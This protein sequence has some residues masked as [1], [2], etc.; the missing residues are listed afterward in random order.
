M[1]WELLALVPVAYNS[2]LLLSSQSQPLLFQMIGDRATRPLPPKLAG[3]NCPG[4][5][6]LTLGASRGSF[7]TENIF[8]FEAFRP[9][10]AENGPSAVAVNVQ[11]PIGLTKGAV[12]G[13]SLFPSV[14]TPAQSP[15]ANFT[16]IFS[17]MAAAFVALY[18]LTAAAPD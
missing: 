11:A 18:V 13:T 9:P 2:V 1:L 7:L 17:A 8:S 3:P 6:P 14:I 10:A 16:R 4:N 15:I 12:A 5:E